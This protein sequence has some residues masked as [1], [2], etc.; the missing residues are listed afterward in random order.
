[1]PCKRVTGPKVHPPMACHLSVDESESLELQTELVTLVDDEELELSE[2]Q[3]GP[4]P[5]RCSAHLSSSGRH[6]CPLCKGLHIRLNI[7][8]LYVL[9]FCR[10]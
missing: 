2:L 4:N 7:S 9:T 6:D 8:S 3:T 10:K 5:L 1:V